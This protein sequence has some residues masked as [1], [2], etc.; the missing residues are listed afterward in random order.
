MIVLG[1]VC[2]MVQSLFMENLLCKLGVFVSALIW[3]CWVEFGECTCSDSTLEV[4]AQSM[5]GMSNDLC[6]PS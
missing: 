4:A 6:Y 1:L 5:V 3:C 2:L